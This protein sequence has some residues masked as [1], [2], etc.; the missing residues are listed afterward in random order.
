[1][2]IPQVLITPNGQLHNDGGQ[3]QSA[4]GQLIEIDFFNV[5]LGLKELF[6]SLLKA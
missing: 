2:E 4:L 3:G 6:F 1:M 5:R